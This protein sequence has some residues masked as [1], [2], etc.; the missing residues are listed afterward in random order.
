MISSVEWVPVIISTFVERSSA[1]LARYC[2]DS[3]SP[4]VPLPVVEMRTTA[5]TV[6]TVM[7]MRGKRVKEKR[8]KRKGKAGAFADRRD[9]E[10]PL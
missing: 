4:V 9:S 6:K 5:E 3:D 7:E 10:L 8:T 2:W 1:V